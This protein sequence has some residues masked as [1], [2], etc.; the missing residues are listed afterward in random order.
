MTTPLDKSVTGMLKEDNSLSLG[1]I[2]CEGAQ[3]AKVVTVNQALS[4]EWREGRGW[5]QL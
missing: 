2:R 1:V 4:G 5:E 3:M